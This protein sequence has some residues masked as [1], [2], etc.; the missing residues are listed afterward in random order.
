MRNASVH[1]LLLRDRS[2]KE[3]ERSDDEEGSA[4]HRGK[5]FALVPSH[6]RDRETREH[7]DRAEASR[8]SEQPRPRRRPP[9][10]VDKPNEPTDQK[11]QA[12]EDQRQSKGQE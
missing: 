9:S 8:R 3:K 11:R 5:P 1:P 12:E 4:A 2:P 10:E 7:H 6:Q